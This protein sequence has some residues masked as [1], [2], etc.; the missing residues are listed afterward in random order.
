MRGAKNMDWLLLTGNVY[1][2]AIKNKTH[3]MVIET[4]LN[5]IGIEAKS[6]KKKE[7]DEVI[8]YDEATLID[9]A[10][11]RFHATVGK[12]AEVLRQEGKG[13]AELDIFERDNKIKMRLLGFR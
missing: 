12:E 2:I 4:E 8:E 10:G 6:F 7:N 13:V 5:L 1:L 3:S 9:K 11:N